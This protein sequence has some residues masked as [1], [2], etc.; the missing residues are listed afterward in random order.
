M[1]L[2]TFLVLYIRTTIYIQ[3]WVRLPWRLQQ[4]LV[5]KWCMH[6]STQ[7]VRNNSNYCVIVWYCDG[8][9][10]DGFFVYT[11]GVLCINVVARS[12]GL[13]QQLVRELSAAFNAPLSSCTSSG[14][15]NMK[16]NGHLFQIRPSD[17][18]LNVVVIAI[19]AEAS[20]GTSTVLQ[21]KDSNAN[22]K[23]TGTGNKKQGLIQNAEKQYA[24]RLERWLEVCA[25][26]QLPNKLTI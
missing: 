9:F 4:H 15:R 25:E 16:E 10:H 20:A 21:D 8:I 11:T 3:E 6:Y 17:E 23:T 22:T 24:S 19:K 5:C 2:S 12:D 14:D 7:E 13:F 26:K 1:N 18:T